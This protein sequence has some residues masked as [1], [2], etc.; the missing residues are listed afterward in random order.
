MR[1]S[2]RRHALI[3][4][5]PPQRF[6]AP[7]PDWGLVL[8]LACAVVACDR[9]DRPPADAGQPAARDT[10]AD[11]L[12]NGDIRVAEAFLTP[13]D[14]SANGR[15]L[16]EVRFDRGAALGGTVT[17]RPTDR[18]ITLRDDGQ[19]GDR[20]A[21]D[22]FFSATV[23]ID[24]RALAAE[25]RRFLD[26]SRGGAVPRFE[27]RVQIRPVPFVGP[28]LIDLRQFRQN[29][30]IPLFPLALPDPNLETRSLM[31]TDPQVVTDPLRT[32]NP[33]TSVGNPTGRWTF[34]HLM[35]QMANQAATSITPSDFTRAWLAQWETNQ[36]VNTFTIPARAAGIKN[37]IIN[38]WIA[39]SGGP[40]NPLDLTKAPFRLLAIVNRVDLRQNLVY[41]GGSAGE[42]RFVFGAI[43]RQGGACTPMEF[44]VI[45]EYGINKRSCSD[46]KAWAKQWHD[47]AA[48]AP[49]D[50]VYRTNL[51]AITEQFVTAG[52]N[53][54]QTPNQSALNQL[55]TNEIALNLQVGWELREFRLASSGASAG[56]LASVTVKQEPDASFNS[57]PELASWVNANAAA[58]AAGTHQVPELHPNGNAFLG[59]HS[60]VPTAG[61][62][63]GRGVDMTPDTV[64]FRFSLITCSGCHAGETRTNFTH[65]S[66][67]SGIPAQL[68]QFLTGT[69]PDV[70]DPDLSDV[71]NRTVHFDDLARRAQD[72]HDLVNSSCLRQVVFRPIVRMPH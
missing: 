49:S 61:L 15:V 65:V 31:I 34:G 23:P 25:Q 62:F 2:A 37:R 51:E 68:S 60:P 41:G 54:S 52:A 48:L 24:V 71:L 66:P 22:G 39:A 64:R 29:V 6:R 14:T 59:S 17:I 63:W 50:P 3:A 43:D 40:G 1:A 28:S 58:V 13:L 27:G 30:R 18:D 36:V 57:T 19:E 35:T 47:L 72:L 4:F 33:C 26:L 55:R 10:R 20:T 5:C 32:F 7:R 45:F 9:P 8:L 53:P 69:S 44:T 70:Q 21:R 12:K 56:Q 38:P 46:L 11:S 16:L 67:T 42:G